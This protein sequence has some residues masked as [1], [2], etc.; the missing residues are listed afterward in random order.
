[1]FRRPGWTSG[2]YITVEE[3]KVLNL[4]RGWTSSYSEY[5]LE[6]F[7]RYTDFYE[8]NKYGIAL[9][10]EPT[11]KLSKENKMKNEKIEVEVKV[12]GEVLN[13]K[14][15]NVKT[16][17]E[18]AGKW[19]GIFYSSNGQVSDTKH[20]NSKKEAKVELGKF[21]NIGK[22][23]ILYRKNV[24]MVTSIPVIEVR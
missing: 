13:T 11:N 8:C 17:L 2:S 4:S 24:T 23:L 6:S 15:E 19:V 14:T 5:P 9:I 21:G 7:K 10:N 1:M 12:N 3:V 18:D 20:F 22:T 16:P